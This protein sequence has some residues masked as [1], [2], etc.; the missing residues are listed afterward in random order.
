[1]FFIYALKKNP[2]NKK[3][4]FRKAKALAGQG[5]TEKAIKLLEELATKNPTGMSLVGTNL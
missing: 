3:A 2:D 1:V 5:F 4:S